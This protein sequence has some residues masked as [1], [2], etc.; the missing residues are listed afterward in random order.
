MKSFT[1][2]F[3][4][5][6]ILISCKDSKNTSEAI[7][8]TPIVVEKNLTT[9]EK[10]AE[11]NGFEHWKEV[12]EIQFTFNVDRDE[13]HFE[14]S[15]RWK[16][17]TNDVAMITAKDPISYNRTR[18]DSLVMNTDAGFINDK[19]WLLAPFNLVWDEGITF[20]EKQNV[21]A[22]ISRD[23]LSLLTIVYGPEGGYTPGDAYD[24]YFGSDFIIK[25]WSFRK[26]NAET[27]SLT[28][29]WEDYEDFK[30]INIA[31]M[32]QDSTGGFK[33]YFTNISIKK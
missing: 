3:F 7:E 22:P 24:F 1:I 18:M 4:A 32:H 25:E 23:T 15:W 28:T 2:F 30:G 19:Y 26:S 29:T 14:R 5:S 8:S 13:N 17:K 6:L 20:S 10:I 9:A 12:S 21:Q 16:P 27:P 33:L 31:K 11:A